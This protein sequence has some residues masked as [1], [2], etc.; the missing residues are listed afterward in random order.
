LH[1]LLAL[2]KLERNAMTKI[3]KFI[4]WAYL[5]LFTILTGMV[6]R[7]NPGLVSVGYLFFI[8]P[9]FLALF[10]YK[11]DSSATIRK[12]AIIANAIFIIFV[13][14]TILL[15]IF[16]GQFSGGLLLGLAL[17]VSLF[18]PSAL[19]CYSIYRRNKMLPANHAPN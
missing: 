15:L 18:I 17:A 2:N 5:I 16:I 19:N 1:T 13:P 10:S 7:K 9:F 14:L 11:G 8:A 4:N 3:V 6:Y 12:T